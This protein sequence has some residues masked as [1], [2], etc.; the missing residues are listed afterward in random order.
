LRVY[1]HHRKDKHDTHTPYPGT[2]Q[3]G[4]GYSDHENGRFRSRA[5]FQETNG[6]LRGNATRYLHDGVRCTDDNSPPIR[7]SSPPLQRI[8]TRNTTKRSAFLF[9]GIPLPRMC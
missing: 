5:F 1:N 6:N 3:A 2:L 4:F 8:S 9:S 7:R